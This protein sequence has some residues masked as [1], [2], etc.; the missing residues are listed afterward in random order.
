MANLVKGLAGQHE[1]RY[2]AENVFS[3]VFRLFDRIF[4]SNE[5]KKRLNTVTAIS[6]SKSSYP[7]LNLNN[8]D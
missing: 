8:T 3:P 6:F 2:L 4:D 5:K 1:E 7:K